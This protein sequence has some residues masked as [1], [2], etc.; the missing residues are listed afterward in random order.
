MS[1]SSRPVVTDFCTKELNDHLISD[2]L[3]GFLIPCKLERNILQ[4]DT[5]YLRN[6]NLTL[7]VLMPLRQR[8][9]DLSFSALF[10]T[11]HL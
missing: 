7:L 2:Y 5:E 9:F 4:L 11:A 10:P 6:E 3:K 1:L 8:L